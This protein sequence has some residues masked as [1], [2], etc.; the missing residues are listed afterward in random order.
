MFLKIKNGKVEIRHNLQKSFFED[1]NFFNNAEDFTLLSEGYFLSDTPDFDS[2]KSLNYSNFVSKYKG[3]FVVLRHNKADNSIGVYNDLLSKHFVYY[4]SSED[5]IVCTNSYFDILNALKQ[6][7][8]SLSIDDKGIRSMLSRGSFTGAHTYVNEIKFLRAF[9]YIEITDKLYVSIIPYPSAIQNINITEARDRSYQLFKE[10]CELAI[11]KNNKYGR[12]HIASLSGG[13]DTRAVFLQLMKNGVKNLST[14]TYAQNNSMDEIIAKQ[15]AED[16]Q[17]TN[18][19]YPLDNAEFIKD[20]ELLISQNEGQM[21][22]CGSTGMYN[23]MQM[24]DTSNAGLIYMGIGGG[25]I[26][27]DILKV[28]HEKAYKD[29]PKK[30]YMLNLDDIRQCQNSVYTAHK[31]SDFVSPFLYEDFFVYAM[32]LPFAIKQRRTLYVEIFKQFMYNSYYTTAFRGQIGNKRSFIN[33]VYNYLKRKIFK[34]DKYSMNP[35][36]YWYSN[37]ESIKAF[38]ND[39]YKSDIVKLKKLGFNTYMLDDNFAG[40]TLAKLRTITASYMILKVLEA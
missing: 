3:S 6:E 28:E 31:F 24:V 8:I 33:R 17:V 20:R 18:V 1:D 14:Y 39:T 15:I 32:S 26:L 27:G 5:L 19:F 12:D 16:Y 2:I 9:E 7:K 40:D 25:E 36:D 29:F 13:M 4:F 10:G 35:M 23:C 11:A 30:S 34:I 22:Y 38:I 21:Y 37:N